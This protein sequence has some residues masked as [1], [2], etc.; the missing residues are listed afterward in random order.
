MKYPVSVFL[1]FF[2]LSCTPN[3]QID[4]EFNDL[5]MSCHVEDPV[6]DLEWLNELIRELD[7]AP[8]GYRVIKLA[9]YES[10]PY[11][12]VQAIW[13]APPGFIY[14]CN[15]VDMIRNN[16]ISYQNFVERSQ[17]LEVLYERQ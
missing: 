3:E 2:C 15:G 17:V 16:G 12:L 7:D 5:L 4:P 6:K 11:F 13:N 1:L 9:R 10:K 14:D 8:A